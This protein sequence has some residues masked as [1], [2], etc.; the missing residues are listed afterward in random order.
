MRNGKRRQA[1]N[2]LIDLLNIVG[3]ISK[4]PSSVPKITQYGGED[5]IQYN[6]SYRAFGGQNKI[7]YSTH[8][9]TRTAI[10]SFLPEQ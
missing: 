5:N 7:M 4:L 1:N 10:I 3:N 6:Y 9:V 2:S 8:F